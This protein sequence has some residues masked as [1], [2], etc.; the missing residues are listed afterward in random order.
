LQALVLTRHQ[1]PNAWWWALA[2]PP[3][4]ALG[5]LVTSYVITTNVKEQFVVFGGSGAIVFGLLTLAL[6]AALFRGAP[7]GGGTAA[8]APR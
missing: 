7:E 4:W 5:W 6:L 2:N 8:T 1:I 3:A